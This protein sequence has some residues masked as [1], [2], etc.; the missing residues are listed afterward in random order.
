MIHLVDVEV[1]GPESIVTSPPSG[2][3]PTGFTLLYLAF[4][5]FLEE[6]APSSCF[7]WR[8]STS[9]NYSDECL[10]FRALV[11]DAAVLVLVIFIG[12]LGIM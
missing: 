2:P 4:P 11:F 10:N 8:S 3:P 7:C 9:L 12:V 5:F 6:S 1:E